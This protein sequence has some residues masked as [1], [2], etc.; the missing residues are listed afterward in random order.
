MSANNAYE[1]GLALPAKTEQAMAWLVE[2]GPLH[3][4]PDLPAWLL[5]RLVRAE[6][7][8][9]L[10]RGVYL[11][12]GAGARLLGLPAAASQLEPTGY[13]SFYGALVLHGLTDQDTTR[14][15]YVSSKRQASLRFGNERLDFVPWPRRLRDAEVQVL[16][17]GTESIRIA[18][19]AQAI[20]DALEA[21]HYA[22]S[23]PEMIHVLRTGLALKKVSVAKVRARALKIGSPALARRL[24]LL[25]EL[26]TGHT[27]AQL[28]ELAH[29]SNNWTRVAGLGGNATVRDSRWRLE[30][31]RSRD[32]IV[33]AV[34]E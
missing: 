10:R 30:L 32:W 21:P 29:R 7:I 12:P 4:D 33:G 18:S 11:A 26:T 6:R 9:K 15:G 3:V 20:C 16:K 19:P 24:G 8:A 13:L 34:R 22:Q 1:L 2:N 14:W 25:L 17:R 28:Q 5:H 31:P 27:D 23:W